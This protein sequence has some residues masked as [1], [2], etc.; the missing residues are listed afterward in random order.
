MILCLLVFA[1]RVCTR[2]V[3]ILLCGSVFHYSLTIL[4]SYL[5]LLSILALFVYPECT[6]NMYMIAQ[7]LTYLSVFDLTSHE[8]VVKDVRITRETGV[9]G[10][11]EGCLDGRWFQP[12]PP[13]FKLF[14]LVSRP[15]W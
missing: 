14:V 8:V 11:R 1:P 2:Y 4:H 3:F 6:T 15:S 9:G 7:V 13:S 5:G 12:T 10:P